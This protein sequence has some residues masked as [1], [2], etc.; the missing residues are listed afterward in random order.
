MHELLG[1]RTAHDQFAVNPQDDHE[2]AGSEGTSESMHVDAPEPTDLGTKASSKPPSVAA[3]LSQLQSSGAFN[4]AVAG[5]SGPPAPTGVSPT[6]PSHTTDQS[7]IAGPDATSAIDT[8]PRAPH[9]PPEN[10]RACTFQQ[11]LPHL[12]RLS[13]DR[14]FLRTLTAVS[15][16][17]MDRGPNSISLIYGLRTQRR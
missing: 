6:H 2:A 15:R 10:L 7:Q 16:T 17:A 14:D 3:L 9:T 5:P 4:N 12:A 8:H 11:A 13:G 1:G